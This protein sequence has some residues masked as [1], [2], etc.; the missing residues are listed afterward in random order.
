VPPKIEKDTVSGQDT[1]GHEWDGLKELNTPLPKWW[2]YTFIATCVWAA[3][4][5]LLYPSVPGIS[6]YFHGVLGYSQRSSVDA[7]VKALAG[8]RSAYMDKIKATPIAAVRQDPQLMEMA[9]T[10]G[11]IAFANNCQPC[12]GAGGAGRVGFPSLADDVWI[13]G[14]KLDD[15]EQTITHGVRS[16][17]PDTRIAQM[18]KFGADGILKP[19]EIAAVADYVMTLFGPGPAG[20]NVAKGKAVFAENCTRCHGDNGDGNRELGG[21][22]LKGAVHLYGDTR[23]MVLSQLNNPRQG[24]M[25]NWNA[26]LDE[27][28][29]KSL[30][31]YVHSLGGGE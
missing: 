22:P 21:P 27:A 29:I 15:I 8:Q 9:I 13:W 18:P 25:P 5:C 1:T 31:L 26:R 3:V 17:D 16:G 4:W 28:T 23:E 10:A 6:G 20:A 2:L 24:V 7:E 19:A 14:G 30:A 11:R 12:H